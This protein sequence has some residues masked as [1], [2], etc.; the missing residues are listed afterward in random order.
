VASQN[1]QTTLLGVTKKDYAS[2]IQWM[3][4]ANSELLPGLSKWFR[5][6][7]GRD[8][9]N[10]K[11][12]SDGEA[13]VERI[14]QIVED[15]LKKTT[16]LVGHRI[17]LA[18]LV[19]A[20][21]YSRGFQYV[22]GKQ[23]RGKYP[24]L[25]RWYTTVVNQKMYKEVVGEATFIDEAVKYT[26]P[27]KE[28]PPKKEKE[29]TKAPV[30]AAAAEEED[31]PAPTPKA[32]HPLEALGAPSMPIDEW[33]RKYSNED[34]RE[35]AIPWFWEHYNAEEYSL[36]RVD[37]KYNDELTLIFMSSNLV[38]GFFNRLAASTK[39]LFGCMVV[40]GENKNNGLTGA[41][42]VRGKNAEPAFDVAP[43][44]E[45]YSFSKLDPSNSEDKSFLEN[46][47]SWDQPVTIGGESK[48][49]ADGKVF[50]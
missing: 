9:Y 2:V 46:M 38:G 16:F 19:L 33:K 24:N 36:W 31:E 48:T 30:A 43:D 27:K 6:L 50:K 25:V 11:N 21:H 10:K 40:F 44:W 35:V 15:Y 8:P 37:Y 17:T 47:W 1:P 32:K 7:I 5:P 22:L 34:T 3:S 13:E 45:S 28:A 29:Q 20:G 26:P 18:D 41:F 49:I 4:F 14:S 23:W 39:Y 12:V 42:L